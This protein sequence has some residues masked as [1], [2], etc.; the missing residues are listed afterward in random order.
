MGLFGDCMGLKYNRCATAGVPE[1]EIGQQKFGKRI[2]EMREMQFGNMKN[3]GT[4]FSVSAVPKN[5]GP[6]FS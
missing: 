4:Y 3:A 6:S 5:G 1:I 2:S